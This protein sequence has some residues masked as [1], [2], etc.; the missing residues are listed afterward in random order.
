MKMSAT[1]DIHRTILS[2]FKSAFP[3]ESVVKFV[4]APGRVNLIG[5]HTDYNGLP[6]LPMAI[7]REIIISYSPYSKSFIE[8]INTAEYPPCNFP[9]SGDI[10]HYEMGEWGNYVKAGA[11]ALWNWTARHHPEKLPLNGFR[12]CVGG[13]IPPGVGL[14]SSSALVVA[15][16]T[17]LVAVNG[18]NISKP[19]LADLL[20]RGERY[21]GTEGGG[22]D[23][24][25]SIMSEKGKA[26]KIDFFPLRTRP[27][28][29]P[30][31]YEI[32]VANSLVSA[33][34]TGNAR[35]AYNMR[36]AECK[37]SLEMFMHDLQIQ[38]AELLRD[39]YVLKDWPEILAGFP[40]GPLSL[41]D[42]AEY[43]G[44]AADDLRQKCLRSF[45]DDIPDS[46]YP[47]ERCRHVLT[48]C[49]RVERT[50]D[51]ME[52]GDVAVMGAL[53][54]ESHA[55]CAL[56]YEI[57]CPELDCLVSA[58]RLHGAIGARLT[59]AGFGG[60]AVA[61]VKLNDVGKLIDGVW[62]T[63]YK[64]IDV[65]LDRDQ[66]IFACLSVDGARSN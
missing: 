58:L 40:D 20:A 15:I 39:I 41:T 6:V 27:V 53:M 3:D 46:F 38:K 24:T 17:A 22:M 65:S 4:H 48:E 42:I 2:D 12:G 8:L 13:T 43:T 29:L 62:E 57:S 37:L 63:Y 45:E 54:N 55:S 64:N 47:K 34:K 56:D 7:D 32:V 66:V 50:V 14:S 60:C 26:L 21:V 5:E 11:Q 23:Q 19:E 25:I 44:K 49:E 16:A 61:L 9:L 1:D 18:L 52:L 33:K 31:G 36:V 59:G 28:P 10:P 30:E 35:L 51:A